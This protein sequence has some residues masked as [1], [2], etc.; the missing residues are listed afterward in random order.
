MLCRTIELSRFILQ[1]KLDMVLLKGGD[2]DTLCKSHGQIPDAQ[3]HGLVQ[4]SVQ[5]LA[6]AR[7]IQHIDELMN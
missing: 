3:S 2:G 1:T 6:L 7:T 5:H 4:L